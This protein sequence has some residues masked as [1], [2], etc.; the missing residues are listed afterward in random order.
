MAH[1]E[2]LIYWVTRSRVLFRTQRNSVTDLLRR[3]VDTLSA[4]LK[5]PSITRNSSLRSDQIMTSSG[6][7]GI[8]LITIVASYLP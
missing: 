7:N 1:Y 2:Y 3:A 8:P 6:M 4:L 5:C